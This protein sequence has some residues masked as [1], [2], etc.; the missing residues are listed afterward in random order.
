MIYWLRWL[1]AVC[2]AAMHDPDF[3]YRALI[4]FLWP[5]EWS[6]RISTEYWGRSQQTWLVEGY[7]TLR[8]PDLWIRPLEEL[9]CGSREACPTADYDEIPF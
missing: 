1:Q 6:G 4:H 7:L 9:P 2:W 3:P 5:I 8:W